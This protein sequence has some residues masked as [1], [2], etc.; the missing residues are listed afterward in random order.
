LANCRD[1]S[2]GGSEVALTLST[3][4][5]PIE[6]LLSASYKFFTKDALQG[7]AE[8]F[9]PWIHCEER[10]KLSRCEDLMLVWTNFIFVSNI[11]LGPRGEVVAVF[12]F[13]FSALPTGVTLNWNHMLGCVWRRGAKA[14]LKKFINRFYLIF[15]NSKIFLCNGIKV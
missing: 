14:L 12:A 5:G 9:L 15:L 10:L 4:I 13:R 7:E 2:S 11:C 8:F 1:G 6:T 3:T